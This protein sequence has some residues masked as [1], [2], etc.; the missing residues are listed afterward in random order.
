MLY[1]FLRIVQCIHIL[2]CSD[3]IIYLDMDKCTTCEFSC[4][5][6][7]VFLPPY[8]STAIKLIPIRSWNVCVCFNELSYYVKEFSM[9]LSVTW[10]NINKQTNMK[11][12][13]KNS[14]LKLDIIIFFLVLF[15]F[16][17][18]Y[19]FCTSFYKGP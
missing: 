4:P 7:L 2:Y 10:V 11:K 17:S 9:F 6:P 3:K 18:L 13:C 5:V 14:T 19:F 1:I 8:K 15:F 16:I 12:H